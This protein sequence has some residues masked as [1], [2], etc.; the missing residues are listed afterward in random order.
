MEEAR[1]RAVAKLETVPLGRMGKVQQTALMRLQMFMIGQTHE[2]FG[3]F[4]KRAQA[5]LVAAADADGTLSGLGLARVRQA[6]ESDWRK[7]FA[8]WQA[9]FSAAQREA[10][11]IPFGTMAVFHQRL[12]YQ[13]GVQPKRET[14]TTDYVFQQQLQAIL[15][16]TRSR[17]YGDGWQLSTRIWNLGA[18]SLAGIQQT[19]FAGV[20]AGRSAWEIAG[21]LERY[22]GAGQDCPRW[23]RQRLYGLTKK[24]IAGGDRRGLLSGEDCDGRGVSY[25]ALRLARTEIQFDHHRATDAMMAAQPW[26]EKEQ[27]ILSGSHPKA[28]ICDDVARGGDGGDGIY[29]KGT[30]SLPLHPNCICFKTAVL[31]SA[32]EFSSQLNGWLKGESWPAM[33]QYAAMLGLGTTQG[34]TQL[35]LG[36]SDFMTALGVWL[37]GSENTLLARMGS[38]L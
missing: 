28:D 24:D 14:L 7:T 2:M 16:A 25:N 17:I 32:E 18:E 10:A 27:V 37:D 6:I 36:N 11:T 13:K 4:G 23:T 33:D 8:T 22:L 19:L 35:D 21:D 20:S 1:K 9:L 12:I 31:I 15:D 30:I 38:G 34:V 29:P 3:E 5:E 26:V